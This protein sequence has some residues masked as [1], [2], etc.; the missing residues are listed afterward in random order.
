MKRWKVIWIALFLVV[1]G[2]A[3][4]VHADSQSPPASEDVPGP[5]SPSEQG[6]WPRL[7]FPRGLRGE[8]TAVSTTGLTLLTRNEVSVQVNVVERTQIWLVETQSRGTLEDIEVGDHILAQGRRAQGSAPEEDQPDA[9]A[10]D[11]RRIVVA[12]DGDKVHGRVAAV[13]GGVITVENKEGEATIVTGE[14]TGFWVGRREGSLDDV[15]EGRF[16]VAFGEMQSDGS[17]LARLVYVHRGPPP[18]PGTEPG[19]G[20]SGGDGLPDLHVSAEP[21]E[22]PEELWEEAL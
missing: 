22:L 8:V 21:G 16:V 18:G 1:L 17:L 6:R 12:P 10:M 5:G 7:R 4:V 2:S 13:E 11:A 3:A 9:P 14:D 15:T 19:A 20:E